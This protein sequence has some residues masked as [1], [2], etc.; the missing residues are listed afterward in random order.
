MRLQLWGYNYDPE[1][2]GIAPVSTMLARLLAERGWEVQ[3]IA[4]HPHYPEP[5]WGYRLRPYRERRDGIEVLRL[6]LWI[7]RGSTA[8]R[9]RQEASFAAALLG[10]MPLFGPTDVMLAVSPSFPA[11]GPAVLNARARRIPLVL[12]LHDLLP[13]GA[14]S[15]GIVQDGGGVLKAARRLERLAYDH[16]DRIVVLSKPFAD[17]LRAKGV[18][19]SK[20]ELIYDPAT[21]GVPAEVP[22]HNFANGE[23]PRVLCM[24]NIGVSQGLTPLVRAFESSEAMRKHDVHLVIL[25]TGIAADDARAEIR[26]DRVEMP[27]LVTDE[28]LE[29]ELCSATLALVSQNY[30][31]TEFNLPSKIMNYMAY[32]LPIVAAVNP[33]SEAARLVREAEA[34]WVADSSEPGLLPEAIAFA[35]DDTEDRERR[36]AAAHKF[37]MGRFSP[38]AFGD[39]FDRVLRKQLR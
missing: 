34:G 2:T 35:L 36:A 31:G 21:R 30:E 22:A 25:G 18:P 32:G 4:A 6:P 19:D 16:A 5:R 17:H 28:R 20:L 37:A 26:S 7:G 33:A 8:A 24:G 39:D 27:G 12:W 38:A 9:L 1:P 13:D 10:T 11:L 3:V 23:P 15:A 29:R 14:A